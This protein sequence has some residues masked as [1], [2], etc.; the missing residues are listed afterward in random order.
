MAFGKKKSS[1]T[2]K[3]TQTHRI[4]AD[5][6]LDIQEDTGRILV[7]VEELGV[8]PLD[9]LIGDMDGRT[10]SIAVSTKQEDYL[11]LDLLDE[12]ED[13]EEPR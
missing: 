9:R 8:V 5:G 4:T 2:N 7:E 13:E 11:E 12:D 1:V 3:L 6:V 10:V